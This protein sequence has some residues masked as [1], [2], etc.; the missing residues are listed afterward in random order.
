MRPTWAREETIVLLDVTDLYVNY[1][2]VDALRGVSLT[3]EEGE[4][5]AVIGANG[6]GKS[7]LLWT[8]AG[9]TVPRSGS[10]LLDG[11]KIDGCTSEEIANRGLSLVPEG[12]HVFGMLS[13]RE[14][15][16]LA[17]H[18]RRSGGLRGLFQPVRNTEAF[19]HLLDRFPALRSR[20]DTPAGQ[21][22]GGEQQQLVLA[23]ALLTEPRL[24]L[25]DEPSFGLAP[26]VVETVFDNLASLRDEGRTI[27]VIEQNAAMA[28]ELADRTYLLRHGEVAASGTRSELN[29]DGAYT[30]VYLG[31]D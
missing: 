31:N 17:A 15:L 6:A 16:A 7:T 18:V 28:V 12:R 25:L 29:A 5:V 20:L 30:T 10:V 13:V 9:V 23:R 14:N 24:L 3:V 8:I 22:S 1:G 19:E 11:Q 4:I 21:L 26:R 2:P 27:L